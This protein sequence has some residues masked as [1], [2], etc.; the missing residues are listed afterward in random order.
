MSV[1]EAA[2]VFQAHRDELGF[3]NRAQCKEKDLVTVERNGRV[4]GA[5]LGNHCVRK[6][7]S[8]VYELAVLPQYRRDGIAETLVTRFAAE[9]PHNTLVAK[10][11]TELPANEFYKNGGWALVDNE[12]GKARPLNVWELDTSAFI[13][14]YVT[15]RGGEDVASAVTQSAALAGVE[16][17][18]T[19]ERDDAPQFIDYPFTDPNADFDDH[20]EVVA[21][22]SPRLT[23]A[24]D[25]EDGRELSE[26]VRMADELLTHAQ[27]VIVVPKD[28]RPSDVPDRFRVGMTVGDF[29]SM[30]EWPVYA[31]QSCDS[32][33]LLGGTPTEQLKMLNYVRVD[34]MDS[35]TMGVRAKY[36]MWDGKAIHGGKELTYRQRLTRSLDNYVTHINKP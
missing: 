19:W 34:S 30:A 10:C 25:V 7:Q 5:L 21:E 9:S 4:V 17:S 6:P 13:R 15:V 22:H 3:V 32:V 12:S 2:E 14:H 36:G 23:V 1:T 18:E 31:Y 28:C 8:T 29:G 16:S 35:F 27:N 20:L 11:P 26:V 24:P 33:H